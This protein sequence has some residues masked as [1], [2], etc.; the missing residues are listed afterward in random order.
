MVD[1]ILDLVVVVGGGDLLMFLAMDTLAARRISDMFLSVCDCGSA[2]LGCEAAERRL[3]A[4][5][6]AKA[7]ILLMSY[8]GVDDDLGAG[9]ESFLGEFAI[10]AAA[11]AFGVD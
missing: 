11:R 9:L 10:P 2:D 4:F 5:C 7:L 1:E 6:V 8:A 3:C